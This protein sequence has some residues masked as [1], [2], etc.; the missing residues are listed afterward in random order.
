VTAGA[1]PPV[2]P[3]L[4]MW[5]ACLHKQDLLVRAE[6]L[7]PAGFDAM[8]AFV[9]DLAA[10]EQ[11]L[12]SI[13]AVRR[14]LAARDAPINC[15]DVYLGWYPG[16]DPG[17][18]GG[19][20]SDLLRATEHEVLRYAS[21]IGARFISI[22]APFWGEPAPLEVVAEALG[23]FTDRADALG[24]RPHLE[25][26]N[27][28]HVSTVPAALELL[29]AVGRP[30]LGLVLDTYNMARAGGRPSD[31][32]A[33]PYEPIF[34]VQLVDG[35]QHP[36]RDRFYDSLHHRELPGE[37]VLPVDDYLRRIAAKGPLAPIGPEV[38][39]DA[40]VA[41]QPQDAASRCADVT[42]RFLGATVAGLA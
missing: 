37:G 40:L 29:D 19:A 18:V 30:T 22:A 24:I 2:H 32:D 6:C 42:R 4:V 39:N 35:A 21:E 10:L 1:K 15:V 17:A 9:T 41:M 20:A 23:S 11:R 36:V 14:E 13:D 25:I 34:Q 16:H 27:G 28:S 8:T 5:G 33:V 12:G 3:Q 38:F 31:I 7:R 26:S